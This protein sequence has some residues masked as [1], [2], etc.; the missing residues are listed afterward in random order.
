[1]ALF[2]FRDITRPDGPDGPVEYVIDLERVAGAPE[3]RPA[4]A[5]G[6]VVLTVVYNDGH[7]PDKVHAGEAEARR[8]LDELTAFRGAIT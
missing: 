7:A 8:F 5:P 4:S 2:K 3:V 6:F 1:M